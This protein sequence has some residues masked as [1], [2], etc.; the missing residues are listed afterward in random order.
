MG[1]LKRYTPLPRGKGLKRARL[2]A[3][4]S[5]KGPT[6]KRRARVNP[7]NSKRKR[8]RHAR[9]FGAEA[10]AVRGMKCLVTGETPSVPA[11]VVSVGAGGGRFDIIPLSWDTH[12][13]QHQTG[14][15]TF[16]AKYGI[17]LRA[18]ADRVA[19]SHEYP[20]GMRGLARRWTTARTIGNTFE[21]DLDDYE[22]EALLGWVRRRMEFWWKPCGNGHRTLIRA[23][24][25]CDLFE[26]TDDIDFDLGVAIV[27]LCELAGWPS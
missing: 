2:S 23:A 16:A 22:R 14:I 17:D 9:N 19:L 12:A 10:D 5:I 8:E 1:E 24:I 18:Q 6:G 27:A 13:E 21:Q 3:G 20:L 4:C 15:L 11:H 26:D 7:V 25:E